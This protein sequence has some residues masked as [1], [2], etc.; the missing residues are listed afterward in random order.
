MNRMRIELENLPD[1]LLDIIDLIN[2]IEVQLP[3]LNYVSQ[4]ISTIFTHV[5]LQLVWPYP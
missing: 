1:E 2:T 3:L 5:D 4:L